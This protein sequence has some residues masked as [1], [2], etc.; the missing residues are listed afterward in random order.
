M[1]HG[2]FF[3]FLVLGFSLETAAPSGESEVF[4]LLPESLLAAMPILDFGLADI[5]AGELPL[6]SSDFS[7]DGPFDF[8]PGLLLGPPFLPTPEPPEPPLPLGPYR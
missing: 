4:K 8:P 5:V 6:E 3:F 1:T 7:L 2:Y